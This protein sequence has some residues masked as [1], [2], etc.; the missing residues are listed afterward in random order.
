MS[1]LLTENHYL[2][3]PKNVLYFFLYSEIQH[4]TT[5]TNKNS[6]NGINADCLW[7]W[8]ILKTILTSRNQNFY[9]YNAISKNRY[10]IFFLL[11]YW[12]K[13]QLFEK[14]KVNFCNRR[15]TWDKLLYGFQDNF[16]GQN[17]VTYGHT[18]LQR[19][20]APKKHW[21]QTSKGD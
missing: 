20:F 14:S 10:L 16:S 7:A 18:E 13:F 12:K 2:G 5:R 19:N 1:I 17:F 4:V 11:K 3:L 15:Y 21:N 9:K 6:K 8:T